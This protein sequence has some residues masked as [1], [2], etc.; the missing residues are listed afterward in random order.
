[1]AADIPGMSDGSSYA[2]IEP[3]LQLMVEIASGNLEAR[4][5]LVGG[6]DAMDALVG[7]LNM[8][9]EELSGRLDEL[10]EANEE[11]QRANRE[12]KEMQVQLVQSA[13]MASLGSMATGIA[14]ELNQPLSAIRMDAEMSLEHL[15]PKNLNTASLDDTRGALA[16]ILAQV[17]RAA[18]IVSHLRT[19]GRQDVADALAPTDLDLVVRNAHALF[20]QQ[21]RLADV[22]AQLELA[23]DCPPAL[24]SGN[25]LEQVL[26]NL[27]SNALHAVSNCAVK[28]IRLRTFA[29]DSSVF[30]EVEDSGPGVPASIRG[31]I[32]E[33][34]FTSKPEGEGTGLGLAISFG[35]VRD[36][37][38][39]LE[40]I[41]RD[42]ARS[43]DRDGAVFRVR[44]PRADGL[45]T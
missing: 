5:E 31:R 26:I 7:G 41:D 33:P 11:L 19:F 3:A 29:D 35:I 39:E 24:A 36:L 8:L 22:D 23:P 34:F 15:D 44:L 16:H 43:P 18:E 20:T 37:G 38:G 6:G 12:L 28:E 13:K 1:V 42:D 17:D 10:Q 21:L 30:V 40:L 14:H 45:K 25:R 4:G 27:L 9:A 32:F 2:R